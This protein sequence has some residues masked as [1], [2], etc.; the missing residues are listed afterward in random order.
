MSFLSSTEAFNTNTST[1]IVQE[2]KCDI[3]CM[4][5]GLGTLSM[6]LGVIISIL[7][8]IYMLSKGKLD[9]PLNE[10]DEEEIELGMK[11]AEKNHHHIFATWVTTHRIQTHVMQQVMLVICDC[12][13]MKKDTGKDRSIL[14]SRQKK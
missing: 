11:N 6:S 9:F 1:N 12:W 8:F 2:K 13:K 10:Q 7:A 3:L 14:L 5:V 4:I